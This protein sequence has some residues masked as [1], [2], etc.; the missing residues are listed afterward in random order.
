MKRGLK[1]SPRRGGTG[2]KPDRLDEKRIERYVENLI[3][4]RQR[5]VSMKRGLKEGARGG[6]GGGGGVSLDEKRIERLRRSSEEL[7]ECLGS[8]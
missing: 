3:M 7:R 4:N 2:K 5:G 6:G 1:A 8:R